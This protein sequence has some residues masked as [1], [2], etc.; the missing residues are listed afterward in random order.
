MLVSLSTSGSP[1]L[2]DVDQNIE[3]PPQFTPDGRAL[4]YSVDQNSVV[5]L[6]LQPLS[7]GPR[8]RITNFTSGTNRVYYFSPDGKYLGVLRT[9]IESDVVLL[10]ETTSPPQ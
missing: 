2:I 1:K 7:G 4:V 5:N 9:L 3:Y 6:W 10:R 8:R